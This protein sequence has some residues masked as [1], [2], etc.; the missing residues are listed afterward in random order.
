MDFRLLYIDPVND[1]FVNVA[2]RLVD[3]KGAEYEPFI[4]FPELDET[5]SS[6]SSLDLAYSWFQTCCEAHPECNR[7][8]NNESAWLPTRLLDIGVDGDVIWR[9][10]VVAQDGPVSG[11]YMTLS[12]RWGSEPS[13]Q[14]QQSN[15]D[16]FRQGKPIDDLPRTFR[17]MITVARRFLVR[18]IWI[19]ALCIIQDSIED[20]TTQSATMRYVYANSTCNI[21]ASASSGPEE[22][23]FRSRKPALIRPAVVTAAPEGGEPKTYCLFDR[24]YWSYYQQNNP[25][26]NRG[27][28][29]QEWFLAPRVLYFTRHQMLWECMME[30]KCEGFPRGLPDH[31]SDKHYEYLWGPETP[32]KNDLDTGEAKF[33]FGQYYC[34]NDLVKSYSKCSFTI[35]TDKLPAFSGI[36]KLFQELTGD[37]YIAG[38]W[39]SRFVHFLDWKVGEPRPRSTAYL[40]PSWSW[41]SVESP[42]YPLIAN[43]YENALA[44]LIDIETIDRG[45]DPTSGILYGRATLRAV[46]FAAEYLPWSLGPE[47]ETD[48]HIKSLSATMAFYP[49]TIEDAPSEKRFVF[50]M[51][52]RACVVWTSYPHTRERDSR[53]RDLIA[54][55]ILE[56]HSSNKPNT[57]R[58]IGQCTMEN[59][60]DLEQHYVQHVENDVAVLRPDAPFTELSII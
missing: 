1:S 36:A 16:D 33:S 27:W 20:W 58:R 5:T 55:I 3:P 46:L 8:A 53:A 19:D 39:K 45:S 49:D 47:S 38:L 24:D 43:A 35:P 12:Y 54:C 56:K 32:W 18:Y 7:S 6:P 48:V 14:L 23:L 52:V 21:A 37:I 41:A 28:V 34:W 29:F 59:I 17:D 25:L 42:V 22:G 4:S 60:E 10:R 51:L 40:A 44:T 2:F 31:H 30:H 57:Y 26:Y 50:C 11:P 13:I 15:I 9:L